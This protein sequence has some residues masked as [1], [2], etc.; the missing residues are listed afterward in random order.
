MNHRSSSLSKFRAFLRRPSWRAAAFALAMA[1]LGLNQH[2]RAVD[3]E[4]DVL[5]GA[6]DLGVNTAGTTYT[7]T[8]TTTSD[9]TFAAGTT[10]TSPFSLSAALSIGSLNDLNA[11][12]ITINGTA[13]LTLNDTDGTQCGGTGGCNGGRAADSLFVASGRQP[14]DQQHGGHLCRSTRVPSMRLAH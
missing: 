1:S 8:A 7:T 12:P 6:T 13:L 9:V 5:A 14:H 2:A 11:T 4:D 3:T 10:Y